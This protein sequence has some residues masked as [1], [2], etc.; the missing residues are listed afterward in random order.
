MTPGV[1]ASRRPNV[2]ACT[3]LPMDQTAHNLPVQL[4]TFIGRVEEMNELSKLL[5]DSACRMAT[6]VGPG[7]S[8]KTRLVMEAARIMASEFPDGV[9]FVPLEPVGSVEFLVPAIADSIGLS[10]RGQE[11]PKAQ[12]LNHL[13]DNQLLIVLD[14]FEHL[15]TAA[16][17]LSDM[18]AAATKLKLIVTTRE[19]LKL[20]EEWI[21]P[22][23][24]MR[25][26]ETNAAAGPE[27]YDSVR[28]F[29]ERAQRVKRGYSPEADWA[30]IVRLCQL[31][32]GMPLAVE[33][34]ASWINVL[35]CQE[36]VAEIERNLD[37]LAS[38]LRNVP[39]RHRSVRA[40][41]AQSWSL[42]G[43]QERDVF[44]RLSVFRGTF[45]RE[46]AEEIAGASLPLLSTLVDKSLLKPLPESRY[47]VHELLR[48]YAFEKLSQSS[49]DVSRARDSHSA[50]YLDFLRRRTPDFIG[51]RQ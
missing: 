16:S 19:A 32:W 28:L 12:L 7:G 31:T 39:E 30:A 20:S 18:L 43:Q 10:L 23:P 2:P 51:G 17:V 37:F 25:F 48:Q 1:L 15:I 26:P 45:G 36:I 24:G 22:V 27:N 40:V 38:S 41:F 35:S 9:Y 44:A 47:R 6:L 33:L 50:Y 5:D 29:V 11:E 49:E 13:N 3:C 8:G 14:N 34:A 42:L 21:F 46:A 4:T